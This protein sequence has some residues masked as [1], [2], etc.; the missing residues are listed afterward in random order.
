[1]KDKIILLGSPLS[2]NNI[3]KSTCR[4][5]FASVYMS[6]EGKEL[7]ESYTSQAKEQFNKK[8]HDGELE[9]TVNLYHGT[10]RRSDIDNFNKILFDSL[11]GILWVD[12]SQIV[13]LTTRKHY[14]KSNPRIELEINGKI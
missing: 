7:K 11:T 14:D 9:V 3:Y 13:V 2:T 10:H 6:K 4:G 8:P 12:D 1:M 5:R